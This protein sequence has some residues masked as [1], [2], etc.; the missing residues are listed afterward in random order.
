MDKDNLRPNYFD[1]NLIFI[2]LT[3]EEKGQ[4]VADVWTKKE[5]S[6]SAPTAVLGTTEGNKGPRI[7]I[8][9]DSCLQRTISFWESHHSRTHTYDFWSLQVLSVFTFF[10]LPR[11][12][13]PL[14]FCF[15]SYFCKWQIIV[16]CFLELLYFGFSWVFCKVRSHLNSLRYL[17]WC[18]SINRMVGIQRILRSSIAV[19]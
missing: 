16:C 9:S 18:F 7:I 13:P 19:I 14:N 4:M 15:N 8:T 10:P 6:C 12:L 17:S 3:S 5:C 2:H 1:P 11:F